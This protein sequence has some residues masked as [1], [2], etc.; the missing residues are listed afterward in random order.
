[1]VPYYVILE[2]HDVSLVDTDKMGVS[3][4]VTLAT[5]IWA[6]QGHGYNGPGS[7]WSCDPLPGVHLIGLDSSR[8][9]DC[10]GRISNSGLRFLESD[11]AANPGKLTIVALHHQLK[12]YCNSA[13]VGENDFDKFVLRNGEDVNKILKK[14]PQVVMTLSGHRHISTRYKKEEHISMFTCPSTMTWP[15]RYVVFEL[16]NKRISY[17]TNDVKSSPEIWAEAKKNIMEDKWWHPENEHPMT[18]EGDKKFVTF[19]LSEATKSGII[20]HSSETVK[21]LE[22]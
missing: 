15:M 3:S 16:D 17:T 5:M 11:L 7:H 10:D 22:R 12:N 18:P 21:A 1:M 6:F 13:L 14:H 4:G 9:G 8:T 2:N 19:M 20:P